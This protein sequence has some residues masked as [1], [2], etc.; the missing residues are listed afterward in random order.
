MISHTVFILLW[1]S[2][3]YLM[4]FQAEDEEDDTDDAEGSELDSSKDSAKED[5]VQHVS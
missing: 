5:A 4:M 2:W 3:C 1:F